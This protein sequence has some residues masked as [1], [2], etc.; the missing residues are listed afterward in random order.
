MRPSQSIEDEPAAV[1]AEDFVSPDLI[2]LARIACHVFGVARCWLVPVAAADFAVEGISS[3]RTKDAGAGFFIRHSVRGPDGRVIAY[4][5]LSDPSPRDFSVED[6]LALADLAALAE[7]YVHPFGAEKARPAMPAANNDLDDAQRCALQEAQRALRDERNRYEHILQSVLAGFAEVDGQGHIV[8][9]NPSAE[10]IFGWSA[11]EAIG[12]EPFELMVPARRRARYA[13]ALKQLS[14]GEGERLRGRRMLTVGLRRSGELFPLEIILNTSRMGEQII[15]HAFMHDVG[16]RK[17]DER[18]LRD[19]ATRLR[20]ITDNLPAMV[21][22]LDRDLRYRFHNRAYRDWFGVAENGLIGVD[23]RNFW[24][25]STY[26]QLRPALTDVL[27]GRRATVEYQ[28][29]GTQGPMWLYANLVPEV[30]PNGKVAG[31]YL[32]AQDI[33]ERKRHFQ[34]VEHDAMHDPLTGLPNRR[35]LM[36]RLQQAMERT[37]ERGQVL[38][39]L[40]MDLDGFKRMNDTLGHE[41]GDE[42]LRLFA[43][44]VSSAVRD[45]DF[46]GRLAGD[47]F[48]LLIEGM[49]QVPAD[50]EHLAQSV[51]ERVCGEQEVLNVVVE[52]STSIGAAVHTSDDEETAQELLARADAA[53]YRAKAKGRRCWSF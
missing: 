45:T 46:V 34:Q 8:T 42:V 25:P 3:P 33:S 29:V 52:L 43:G 11:K 35:G 1:T 28:L 4:L 12:R 49:H 14:Q 41:F 9:W 36:K 17:A 47:E 30:R 37:R 24:G 2:R 20:T 38:V 5:C 27:Q 39:V 53:M 6:R 40:F 44:Q 13:R 7:G 26:A 50:V 15:V 31:F 51:L 18:I 21:A 16:R 19:M 23:A 48:V 10:R 22:Y 32:L